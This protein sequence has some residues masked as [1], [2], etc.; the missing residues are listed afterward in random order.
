MSQTDQLMDSRLLEKPIFVSTPIKCKVIKLF[1][2][3]AH[4][5]DYTTLGCRLP[6]AKFG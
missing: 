5:L 2:N 6:H 4:T 3:L 1:R